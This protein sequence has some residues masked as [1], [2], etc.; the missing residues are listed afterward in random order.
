MI[1]IDAAT[2]K[3]V[4]FSFRK[5][6]FHDLSEEFNNTEM[7]DIELSTDKESY[8]ILVNDEYVGLLE[9]SLRNIVDGCLSSPVAYIE[10][11]YVKAAHRKKDIGSRIVNWAKEW[12]RSKN[13][14]E[15]GSDAELDNIDS[16]YFHKAIGFEETYRTVGFKM[17]L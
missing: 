5:D 10:G 3:E 11:I 9:L 14:T 16:Q 17:D 13:C 8:L 12:G 6:L 1:F 2:N 7:E 15:L 4:W